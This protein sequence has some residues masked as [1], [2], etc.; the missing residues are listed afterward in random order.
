[1]SALIVD[2]CLRSLGVVARFAPGVSSGHVQAKMETKKKYLGTFGRID[3][4]LDYF[5]ELPPN[6][7]VNQHTIMTNLGIKAGAWQE[8]SRWLNLIVKIQ[9]RPKIKRRFKP[10][11]KRTAKFQTLY[12][13]SKD[14][15]LQ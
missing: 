15:Y 2:T 9:S 10:L 6:K 13:R 7:E 14:E 5:D 4:I 11:S 8:M 12:H 1:M 3:Q